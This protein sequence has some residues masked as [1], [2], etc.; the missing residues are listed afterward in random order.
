[1]DTTPWAEHVVRETTFFFMRWDPDG[2]L[3]VL[4]RKSQ[5]TRLWC[6]AEPDTPSVSLLVDGEGY[7]TPVPLYRF[8]LRTVRSEHPSVLVH[9]F[10]LAHLYACGQISREDVDE[11]VNGTQLD[12]FQITQLVVRPCSLTRMLGVRTL[13][14]VLRGCFDMGVL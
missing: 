6:R 2:S 13:S 5:S 1:M 14:L 10:A 9:P 12:T 8:S 11:I 7:F 4:F 3:A